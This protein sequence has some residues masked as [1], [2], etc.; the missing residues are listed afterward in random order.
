MG[1]IKMY[2]VCDHCDLPLII[3]PFTPVQQ[4]V[5]QRTLGATQNSATVSSSPTKWLSMM[6]C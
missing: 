4:S 1:L 6:L 3:G 5:D 2:D